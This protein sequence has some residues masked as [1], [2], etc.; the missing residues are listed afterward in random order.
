MGKSRF[1]YN[2]LITSGNSLTIDSVKPGIATTALKDGTGSASMSTD[3][4]FTGSQDLEY[5]IDIHDIGSGESGASQVDQAKFQWSTTTTSWVA[6]G[7]TA[8]S[9]ATD[10]N[11]GVSV[12]FTAGT[13][14]DFA[15]ND[16]W[17]FKGINFFN[18]EKMVDWDR[19][20]RYRSDDVSGS[21]ISINLGT[22]Y[23]VSSLVLYDHNFS[24]GVSITFS[25]ATKSNWVD[26]MP[27]VSE[28]V[29]YGVTK[30]L[31]F[32][33]SA[34]SY[35]F[36]RVEINDSGNADGY[37]EI[38]EL[39]LGDYFEPTG[40]WIGEANRSTQTIFGTNTNLYGKKDLRFFNQKKILEY[41]YAFVSDADAD[42]FEDMLTSIVDKNTG[43][44]QPLYFVE[45]SSSTTKF[46]M[47]WFTEIPRTLKHGDLSGIQ[48][49][50]EETLKSV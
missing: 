32:L 43:T 45:D 42:Q 39:F 27:E 46:W 12:A 11:N 5:L 33:T 24:T 36:W 40:I 18:A 37:I 44:F 8:T 2:N 29:T 31:H 38:G 22:S 7:V 49:S 14:D 41:D 20:T 23:T 50:L 3:G 48:I 19:D 47:T 9:G 35:P 6:S 28:S 25:G 1:L 21:S 17:Y 26:G 10:L 30:I 4:L 15:L 34:A 13:G 16:R